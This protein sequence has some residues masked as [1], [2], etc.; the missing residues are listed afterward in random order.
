MIEIRQLDAA[1]GIRHVGA[2]ADVLVDCVDGGAS[3]S[4]MSPLSQETATAFYE[5]VLSKVERGDCILLATF[6]DG[7]LVGTVQIHTAM[8]PNQPHRA[9]I[10]KLLVLRSARGQG[11][12][13]RLME[14][15]EVVS[16]SIGKTL[17]VLDTV[18]AGAG[19]NLYVRLGWTRAGV[20]PDYALLPDGRPCSTTIFWKQL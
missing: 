7:R 19:E 5:N 14:R 13:A 20:I 15:V 18:T 1:E 6:A 2:L 12:G 16:R 11:I 3:V 17:L 10:A 4:F 9:D 8:P